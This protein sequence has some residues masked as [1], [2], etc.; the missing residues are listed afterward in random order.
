MYCRIL[1]LVSFCWMY[2]VTYTIV[3]DMY[4][5]MHV[6]FY[7]SLSFADT[8]NFF[9]RSVIA[10]VSVIGSITIT[11]RDSTSFAV[12]FL[13]H[14]VIR[15]TP[16]WLCRRYA[17]N[18]RLNWSSLSPTY[19]FNMTAWEIKRTVLS[20]KLSNTNIYVSFDLSWSHLVTNS[21]MFFFGSLWPRIFTR[22][23]ISRYPYSIRSELFTWIQNTHVL[24]DRLRR[25]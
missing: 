21:N 16:F 2:V 20:F 23:V 8:F 7:R 25:R 24:G 6:S 18:D 12:T 22:F 1:Y 10:F 4:F 13:V 3:S 17:D 11:F 14:V 9:F 19:V 15:I 5:S